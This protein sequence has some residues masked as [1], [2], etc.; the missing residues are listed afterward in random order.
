MKTDDF[1]LELRWPKTEPLGVGG[2]AGTGGLHNRSL[3]GP[4]SLY[5]LTVHSRV[6]VRAH[7]LSWDI[8]LTICRMAYIA[9]L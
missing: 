4:V 8:P 7:I 3:M 1:V 5:A 6:C 9:W 2:A